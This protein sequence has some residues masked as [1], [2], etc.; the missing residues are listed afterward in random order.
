MI[1]MKRNEDLERFKGI[2]FITTKFHTYARTVRRNIQQAQ[3]GIDPPIN[4]LPTHTVAAYFPQVQGPYCGTFVP[5]NFRHDVIREMK[6]S[7]FVRLQQASVRLK[8]IAKTLDTGTPHLAMLKL[9]SKDTNDF[10]VWFFILSS[11][12]STTKLSLINPL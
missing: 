10:L 9:L 11:N 7:I 6:A 1:P 4:R 8:Q 2:V 3:S 5:S 12:D